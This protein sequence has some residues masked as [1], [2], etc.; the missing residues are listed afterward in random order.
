MSRVSVNPFALGAALVDRAV[1]LGWVEIESDGRRSAYYI[2]EAGSEGLEEFGVKLEKALQVAVLPERNGPGLRK[3]VSF[4]PP[5]GATGE[6]GQHGMR[7]YAP[8]PRGPRPEPSRFHGS[9][10]RPRGQSR[11]GGKRP[12]DRHGDRR[13]DRGGQGRGNR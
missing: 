9:K 3:S 1:E 4:G 10:P 6:P 2:T 7:P 5:P 12:H 8:S 13:G 11:T